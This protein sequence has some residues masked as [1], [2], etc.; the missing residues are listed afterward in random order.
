LYSKI[1]KD[2]INSI[3]NSIPNSILYNHRIFYNIIELIELNNIIKLE[4]TLNIDYYYIIN[5][6]DV[7]NLKNDIELDILLYNKDKF[8]CLNRLVSN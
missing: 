6:S 1:I 2:R 8:I 4:Y 7:T 5:F 3:P